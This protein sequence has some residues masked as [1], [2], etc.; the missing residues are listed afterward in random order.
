MKFRT[1]TAAFF[2][3]T[4][5]L[6]GSANPMDSPTAAKK[7]GRVPQEKA[8]NLPPFFFDILHLPFPL[9]TRG[10]SRTIQRDGRRV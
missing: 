8:L 10:N 9:L 1:T 7:L 2:I 4:T 3:P 6:I 5:I